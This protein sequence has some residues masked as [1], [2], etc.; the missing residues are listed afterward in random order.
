MRPP[1]VT[2]NDVLITIED[3]L[4]C[5]IDFDDLILLDRNFGKLD[6]ITYFSLKPDG[7]TSL[8]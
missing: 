2:K 4:F 7:W 8:A 5:G 3:I 1:F 6:A